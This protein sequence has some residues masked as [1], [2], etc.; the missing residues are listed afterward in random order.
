MYF[1]MLAF[2]YWFH[3]NRAP[4]YSEEVYY[5]RSALFATAIAGLVGWPFCIVAVV[6]F[7]LH[8]L[9]RLGLVR[10]VAVSIVVLLLPLVC[11]LE[12]G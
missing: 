9:Y 12:H 1:L 4:T 8:V 10:F 7:G 6:P 11:F 3:A 2:G 5:L